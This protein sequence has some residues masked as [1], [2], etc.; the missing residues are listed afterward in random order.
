MTENAEGQAR[1]VLNHPTLRLAGL[2]LAAGLL[3]AG[4]YLAYDRLLAAK[5]ATSAAESA[6]AG[7]AAPTAVPT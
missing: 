6:A 1:S 7:N 2:A 4:G 3:G 5:D